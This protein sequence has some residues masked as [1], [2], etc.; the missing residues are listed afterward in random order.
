MEE[1]YYLHKNADLQNGRNQFWCLNQNFGGRVL[2]DMTT[3]NEIKAWSDAILV[4]VAV[5]TNPS[6]RTLVETDVSIEVTV[7][8][9]NFDCVER[10]ILDNSNDESKVIELTTIRAV[11]NLILAM[12]CPEDPAWQAD[13]WCMEL[14]SE[15]LRFLESDDYDVCLAAVE[16]LTGLGGCATEAVPCLLTVLFRLDDVG[17][18]LAPECRTSLTRAVRCAIEAICLEAP[19]AYVTEQLRFRGLESG[20]ESVV[21]TALEIVSSIGM[22]ARQSVPSIFYLLS[23]NDVAIRAHAADAMISLYPLANED[24]ERFQK[25]LLSEMFSYE[26]SPR[27]VFELYKN[28]LREHM[29]PRGILRDPDAFWELLGDLYQRLKRDPTL[30][31][32]EQNV[33]YFSWR[34]QK[35]LWGL[36]INGYNRRNSLRRKHADVPISPDMLSN[37]VTANEHPSR[38]EVDELLAKLPAEEALVCR[39]HAMEGWTFAEIAALRGSTAPEIRQIWQRARNYLRGLSNE[40]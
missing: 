4:P 30:N 14:F 39:L 28:N 1:T 15:L 17:C 13:Q 32:T 35:T 40:L 37:L 12:R 34:V 8:A 33:Q 38:V 11:A 29:L 9:M 23:A 7:H 10:L 5:V 24:E 31:T 26:S 19:S 21:H 3:L 20:H 2:M 16:L 22:E 27:S 18:C 25:A 36:Y 6:L